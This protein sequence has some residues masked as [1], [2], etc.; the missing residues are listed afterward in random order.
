[1]TTK[2][3]V[4]PILE[5]VFEKP[6][7]DD[8]IESYELLEYTERS[9]S[10][11][12]TKQFILINQ[13]LDTYQY[14]FDSYVQ[15]NARLVRADDGEP[16][17]ADTQIAFVN[18]GWSWYKQVDLFMND[19]LV[20]CKF[21]P[22][23]I[24]NLIIL[25]EKSP[26]WAAASGSLP[27]FI[28]D[29]GDGVNIILGNAGFLERVDRT[30]EG[31]QVAVKL[32]LRDMFGFVDGNKMVFR[33][34]KWTLRLTRE[35]DANI[36]HKALDEDPG[37]VIFEKISLWM[38]TIFPNP[39]IEA[40]LNSMTTRGD[41]NALTWTQT[42]LIQSELFDATQTR[43]QFRITLTSGIPERMFIIGILQDQFENQDKT[44]MI[45]NNLDIES[46]QARLNNLQYP[47]EE[48]L[49]N[50]G[51][52]TTQHDAVFIPTA[53]K[54]D[55]GAEDYCRAHL[56]LLRTADHMT[57]D[58][59]GGLVAY[60]DFKNLFPIFVIDFKHRK[61]IFG[62]VQTFEIELRIRL[63]STVTQPTLSPAG[64]GAPSKYFLFVLIESM[65]QS[66]LMGVNQR[67]RVDI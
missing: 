35:S 22:G 3:I 28:Q 34:I 62:S 23:I 38:A 8:S 51:K 10:L 37:K 45:W 13:D 24:S 16:F 11:A 21:N 9:T 60:N 17:A 1:M 44:L 26:S 67:M 63:R 31:R 56:D 47:Q 20:E 65:R 50:F 32:M 57:D 53:S 27:F 18:N 46:V 41:V 33:G 43:P 4:N 14:L 39:E 19:Q 15:A 59:I 48:M 52:I 30:A 12:T 54:G 25:T 42:E 58:D 29:S 55:A 36:I 6:S 66:K 7:I 2:S 40:Q 61:S 49:T 64:P 5:N